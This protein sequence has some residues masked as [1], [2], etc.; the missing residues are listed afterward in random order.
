[1]LLVG[2]CELHHRLGTNCQL[3]GH[4][5][6]QEC[7]TINQYGSKQ[8]W[9]TFDFQYDWL[10]TVV[11]WIPLV[12]AWIFSLL[13]FFVLVFGFLF[14]SM[15]PGTQWLVS[16]LWSRWLLNRFEY[17][18]HSFWTCSPTH[19]VSTFTFFAFQ[20]KMKAKTYSIVKVLLAPF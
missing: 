15:K 2:S 11:I 6:W 20:H 8:D 5:A 17:I 19:K 3:Y 13:V 12:W 9:S 1:M 14:A 16:L 4:L 18:I 10:K 7:W